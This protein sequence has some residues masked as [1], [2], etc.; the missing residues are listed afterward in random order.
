MPWGLQA[1]LLALLGFSHIPVVMGNSPAKD[2]GAD[3]AAVITKDVKSAGTCGAPGA[4]T[5]ETGEG[6]S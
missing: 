1:V 2:F 3:A 4:A 6:I 5:G